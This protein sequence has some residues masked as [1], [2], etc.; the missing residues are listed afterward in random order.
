MSGYYDETYK[1]YSE[2][3]RRA[4]KPHTCSAC[5]E[6]IPIGHRY[7]H[8]SAILDGVTVYRRCA[9]C[10]TLHLALRELGDGDM[11]PDERLNCGEEYEEHWGEPPPAELA[12]LAFVTP[13]D[14]QELLPSAKPR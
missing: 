12:A 1:L 2:T 6:P 11:W 3:V 10:Q 9:R 5:S 8:V 13:E 4:R 14:A 7:A